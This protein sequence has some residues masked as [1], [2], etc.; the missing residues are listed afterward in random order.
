MYVY[1]VMKLSSQVRVAAGGLGEI[2]GRRSPLLPGLLPTLGFK[3]G[4]KSSTFSKLVILLS[5]PPGLPIAVSS[6]RP[7]TTSSGHSDAC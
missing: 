2:F 6:D 5:L 4:V 7:A 1:T 3:G